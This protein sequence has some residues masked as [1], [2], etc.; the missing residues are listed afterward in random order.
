M[1]EKKNLEK[2]KK[3]K[4][5]MNFSTNLFSLF[6][7]LHLNTAQHL[8]WLYGVNLKDTEKVCQNSIKYC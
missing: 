8:T 2:L 6:T 4:K 7:L 1:R 3:K 5:D